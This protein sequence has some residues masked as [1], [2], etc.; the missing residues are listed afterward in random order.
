[1]KATTSE[2][3]RMVAELKEENENLRSVMIAAAEEIQ[4]HWQA[5]CD[6]EGYGPANL[7][8]RLEK[9]IAANYPGYKFGEFTKMQERITSLESQVKRLE[10]ELGWRKEK[11]K[12][13]F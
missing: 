4:E 12:A 10:Q 1:M 5:H 11:G 13:P 7:M 8:H 2:I 6:S 3:N 9:G